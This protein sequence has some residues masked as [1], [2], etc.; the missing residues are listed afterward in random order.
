MGNKNIKRLIKMERYQSYF[1]E[2]NLNE[3]NSWY[4]LTDN[5]VKKLGRLNKPFSSTIRKEERL[6]QDI[7]QNF[8][9]E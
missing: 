7:L 2:S 8:K 1:K 9:A 3:S 6:A 5:S 4:D